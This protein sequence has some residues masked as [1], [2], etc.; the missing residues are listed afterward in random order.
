MA[1]SM[2]EIVALDGCCRQRGRNPVPSTSRQDPDGGSRPRPIVPQLPVRHE[3]RHVANGLA[4]QSQDPDLVCLPQQRS[5]RGGIQADHDHVDQIRC[6]VLNR[7]RGSISVRASV[8]YPRISDVVSCWL[9]HMTDRRASCSFR[10]FLASQSCKS[11][12][13]HR[14]SETSVF[15]ERR[16]ILTDSRGLGSPTASFRSDLGRVAA[17]GSDR[18]VRPADAQGS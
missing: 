6:A 14:K 5:W 7:P 11:V 1:D 17:R 8:K 12:S 15:G 2:S 9:T 10:A 18:T 16:T 3:R 4:D 13:A